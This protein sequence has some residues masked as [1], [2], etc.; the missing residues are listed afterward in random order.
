MIN[1]KIS[2][3]TVLVFML[4]L[5][6]SS[7]GQPGN[8]ID[9][10]VFRP[11]T[12]T[13]FSIP[14]FDSGNYIDQSGKVVIK[15]NPELG[16][17]NSRA[18][19][20][21]LAAVEQGDLWGYID[22]KGNMVIKPQFITAEY[23]YDGLARVAKPGANGAFASPWGYI[24]K[25]GKLVYETKFEKASDFSDGMA[26]VFYENKYA[27]LTPTGKIAFEMPKSRYLR[28]HSFSE[29]L[30]AFCD[31]KG[32]GYMDKTGKV[33]IKPRKGIGGE[34]HDGRARFGSPRGNNK[35][36]FI[37]KTGKVVIEP[38]WDDAW[39]FCDGVAIVNPGWS[40][41]PKAKVID[42]SGKVIIDFKKA[43]IEGFLDIGRFH[44]GL[45][46]IKVL[47]ALK[48]SLPRPL[49]GFI[50]KTGKIVIKPQFHIV[51]QFNS[52]LAFVSYEDGVG[53]IDKTG[54]FIWRGK[55]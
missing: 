13:L 32:C 8:G 48:G 3:F 19:S 16:I 20:E 34:F 39:E 38:I 6:I 33:K 23:F 26:L 4:A 9:D 40:N 28:L 12:S 29:G 43:N 44:E 25:T 37:D 15:A 52:G 41:E 14:P 30:A 54:N 17:T 7:Y 46:R 11:R 18:F 27:Y 5:Y 10:F 35:Y 45:G 50:D 51:K 31:E 24:D 36:G 2:F 53:Y 42:T 22:T 21:G 49:Y 47:A 1:Q 55:F